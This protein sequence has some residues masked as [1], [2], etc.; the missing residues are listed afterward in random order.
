MVSI[1]HSHPIGHAKTPHT[2]LCP[3]MALLIAD[4]RL[5]RTFIAVGHRITGLML[6]RIIEILGKKV[7]SGPREVGEVLSGVLAHA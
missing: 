7:R 2:H 4:S 1:P 3:S 6:W 5:I